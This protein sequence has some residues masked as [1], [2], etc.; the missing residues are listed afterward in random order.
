MNSSN[1]SL[2]GVTSFSGVSL[3]GVTRLVVE[4]PIFF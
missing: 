3:T 4:A 1:L 2:S